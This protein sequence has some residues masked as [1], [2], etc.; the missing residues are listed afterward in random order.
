MQREM[1][2]PVTGMRMA[3]FT[4]TGRGRADNNRSILIPVPRKGSIG[5]A[6]DARAM[7]LE[8]RGRGVERVRGGVGVH[9]LAQPERQHVVGGLGTLLGGLALWC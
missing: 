6:E 4:G 5:M 7:L 9:E 1:Q 8:A 2:T 3:D